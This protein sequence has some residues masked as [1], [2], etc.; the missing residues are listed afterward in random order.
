MTRRVNGLR[1]YG[2]IYS[3]KTVPDM[4]G[5]VMSYLGEIICS[6][7]K[8]IQ[9]DSD[10]LYNEKIMLCIEAAIIANEVLSYHLSFNTDYSAKY[11]FEE[12]YGFTQEQVLNML[13]VLNDEFVNDVDFE[14]IMDKLNDP[15]MDDG[16]LYEHIRF[17]INGSSI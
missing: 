9:L 6:Q 16:F 8:H 3:N 14:D 17:T 5:Y 7:D 4:D 10:E 2:T 11:M 12:S 13:E 15:D 1:L